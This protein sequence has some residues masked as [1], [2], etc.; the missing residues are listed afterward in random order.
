MCPYVKSRLPPWI[1]VEATDLSL[2]D[3]GRL[4]IRTLVPGRGD[5]GLRCDGA[6][7][8]IIAG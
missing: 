6:C 3:V 1:R 8:P 7:G 4:L 5:P 2:W